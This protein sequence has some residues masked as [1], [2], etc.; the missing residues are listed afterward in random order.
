MCI[1]HATLQDLEGGRQQF[2][3]ICKELKLAGRFLLMRDPGAGNNPELEERI[4]EEGAQQ[5]NL[6]DRALPAITIVPTFG[7]CSHEV[8][9][10]VT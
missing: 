9:A 8:S 4:V 1:Y 6:S 10:V 5:L 2:N 3:A 7:N